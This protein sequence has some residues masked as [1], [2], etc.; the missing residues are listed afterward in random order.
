MSHG[1]SRPIRIAGWAFPF[2]SATPACVFREAVFVLVCLTILAVTVGVPAL[3]LAQHGESDHQPAS[4]ESAP[5][6]GHSHHGGSATGWEGS[7]EGVAYSE[8]NHHLA[9][10]FVLLIGLTELTHALNLRGAAWARMLLPGAL[11]MMGV[12]LLVWSD[13]EAWPIGTMSFAQTFFGDDAEIVQHKTYGVLSFLVGL[14]EIARRSGRVSQVGWMVPLPLFAVIGGLM[15]FGHS[16]GAHP[17][18]AKIALHHAVM[19]TLAVSA[20][21]AR[22]MTGWAPSCL[23]WPQA[24]W[25]AVWGGLI[26]IIGLQLLVY[27]E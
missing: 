9:G 3:G 14:A 15:L 2:S 10:V 23:G 5:D 21:G 16:H 26:M 1:A 17:A 25:E 22:L 13:H 7:Q 11:V 6:H 24:R 4:T 19:G 8:F 20:G 12:F 27:S 18:A